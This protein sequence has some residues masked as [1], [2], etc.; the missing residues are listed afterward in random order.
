M[1]VYLLRDISIGFW[2]TG[3]DCIGGKVVGLFPHLGEVGF[4]SS[5]WRIKQFSIFWRKSRFPQN[6]EIEKVW[7]CTTVQR[8]AVFKL[9]WPIFVVQPRGKCRCSRF[10]PF[11]KHLLLDNVKI[12]AGSNLIFVKAWPCFCYLAKAL[13]GDDEHV[14]VA[15][16]VIV[17]LFRRHRDHF[18]RSSDL[19]KILQV[20]ANLHQVLSGRLQKLEWKIFSRFQRET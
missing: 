11:F 14:K 2:P 10:D 3:D 9:K 20:A 5:Q 17:G 6:D 15:F 18:R 12:N 7:T 13:R 19:G 4:K 16:E 1:C 8:N